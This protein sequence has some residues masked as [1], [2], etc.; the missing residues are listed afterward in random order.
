MLV[1]C[2]SRIVIAATKSQLSALTRLFSAAVFRELGRKGRSGLF[3]RLVAEAC[4]NSISS[5]AQTVADC[6]D[7]AFEILSVDGQRDEYVYRSAVSRK[8][9][10][11]RHSLVEA[12]MLSE[13]RAGNCK[14][15]LVI[16]NGT[17]TAYEIK[18]ERD[19]LV[20]LAMQVSAYKK[21]FAQVNV[22]SSEQHVESVL[23]ITPEDIGVVCLTRKFDLVNIRDAHDCPEQICPVMVFES[24]RS[25]EAVAILNAMSIPIPKVPNTERHSALRE[26]F[27]SLD[28]VELHFELVRTLKRTRSLAALNDLVERLPRSLSAAALSISM[29]IADHQRLLDAVATPLSTAMK[30]N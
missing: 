12:C 13:F 19:S 5:S 28:P 21:I 11:E 2:V 8:V 1:R 24:L 4:I 18:S 6:F 9:L 16:L 29:P 30:W 23:K 26:I 10:I 17:S 22:I 25:N 3:R 20:R 15:D 7:M 14:A 27:S